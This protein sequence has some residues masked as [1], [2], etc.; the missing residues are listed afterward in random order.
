MRTHV[1]NILRLFLI[2]L[3]LL[4]IFAASTSVV[5]IAIVSTFD[6]GRIN[7]EVNS[8]PVRSDKILDVL[9]ELIIKRGKETPVVILID[10]RNSIFAL[11]NV[12]GIVGKA[13]F[14]NV[15]SYC[16]SGDTQRMTEISFDKPAISFSL[17]PQFK[18]GQHSTNDSPI[19]VVCKFDRGRMKY[20]LNSKPVNSERILQALGETKKQRSGETSVVVLADQR[21]SF[22]ALNNIRGIIDKAGFF[23]V[24]YFCFDTNTERMTEIRSEKPAIPFSLNPVEPDSSRTKL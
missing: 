1:N 20:E 19:A 8:L 11:S 12:Q 4:D 5:P 21:N 3:P 14:L 13:G 9:N 2:A 6:Q 18:P 16:F 7:Y 17:P 10:K 15:R 24:Q 22:A 23:H